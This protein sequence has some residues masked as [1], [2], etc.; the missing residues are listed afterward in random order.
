MTYLPD[1]NA[2]IE[3][4]RRS[5]AGLVAK[6]EG[7][8]STNLVLCS[9]VLSELQFGVLRAPGHLQH[10][11]AALVADLRTTFLSLP[12]DDAAAEVS[13]RIRFDLAA[14]GRPIG[15]NDLLI[16]SIAMSRGLIL[17]TH[18]TREFGR[19]AGLMLEDW[20]AIGGAT[21]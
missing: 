6:F 11:N 19:V 8:G 4:L 14:V 12:F 3:Y 20:Q 17:V 5:D 13:A 15:A 21:P 10:Q 9:I 7:L 2:W 18:N 16:A 1:T